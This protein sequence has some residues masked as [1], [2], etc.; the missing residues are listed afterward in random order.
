MLFCYNTGKGYKD[1]FDQ[2]DN[3]VTVCMLANIAIC[4]EYAQNAERIDERKKC[5]AGP[6]LINISKFGENA[7][8]TVI[9]VFLE[10]IFILI[11]IASLAPTSYKPQQQ[12]FFFVSKRDKFGQYSERLP[13]VIESNYPFFTWQLQR[14]FTLKHRQLIF[15]TFDKILLNNGFDRTKTIF[16]IAIKY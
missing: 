8:N 9:K 4:L 11:P 3:E 13:V 2:P 5:I 15:A 10:E 6:P 14:Y 7:T 1:F 16:A 12:H